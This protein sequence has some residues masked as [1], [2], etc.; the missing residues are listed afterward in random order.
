M[1][2]ESHGTAAPEVSG[3]PERY[4]RPQL[5]VRWTAPL[6]AAEPKDDETVSLRDL[7]ATVVRR[8]WWVIGTASTIL[9]IALIQVFTVRPTY[10]ARAVMQV[11]PP[12]G[13]LVPSELSPDLRLQVRSSEEYVLTQA[14]K[15]R[16]ATLARRVIEKLDLGSNE[17]FR[18]PTSHGALLDAVVAS[19]RAIKAILP[20]PPRPPAG[21]STLVD[22]FL[23]SVE[24]Q[25]LRDTRLIAVTFASPDRQLS[26]DTLNAL[27]DEF[28]EQT[29]EEQYATTTHV[30]G[31]L[32]QQLEELR[33]KVDESEAA[34]NAFAA[35]NDIV[36]LDERQ[37]VTERRLAD[38]TGALTVV[39]DELIGQTARYQAVRGASSESF[40]S[41]LRNP[42]M[43]DVERRL[44]ERRAQLAL[45]LS[46][47]GPDWP[48]VKQVR[49]EIADLEAQSIE[50]RRDALAMARGD[51]EVAYDRTRK[52]EAAIED[53]KQAVD[54][55]NQA[56]IQ[57]NN[58]KREVDTN[59]EIYAGLL[60]RLKEAGVIA[61]LA[62]SNIRAVERASPPREPSAPK[63]VRDLAIATVL[64]LLIGVG[65]AFVVDSLD[66]AV[67]SADEVSRLLGLP[68][69]GE[70]PLVKVEENGNR[71]GRFLSRQPAASGPL[72]LVGGEEHGRAMEAYR[73][74]RT[75]ILLS[76]SERPPQRILVTSALPGDGKT[77]TA[78]N[79]GRALAQTGARTVLIDLDM[80]RMSLGQ[81]F[82]M[83]GEQGLST[84]LAGTSDLASQ[85]RD[86]PY[87][88]LL[89]V[90]AG[91]VAPNPAELIG[92]QRMVLGLQ[93]VQE[94]FN[95]VVVD[96][97]PVLDVTDAIVASTWMDGVVLVVR[98]GATPREAVRKAAHRLNMVGAK[99]LGVVVNAVD[100]SRHGHSYYS[101]YYRYGYGYYPGRR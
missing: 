89:V 39:E 76:S 52:L 97:P 20:G 55:L 40:P 99:I 95:Y 59:Q 36:N 88:K 93:L 63:K 3:L 51:Y 68:V 96:S 38:L 41:T 85:V 42:A 21:D 94:Y 9:L 17:T 87:D 50:Q 31:F 43:D 100:G 58:L 24:A 5:P 12:D 54:R 91:P 72:L 49:G 4:E 47:Y 64:G 69:L 92:S 28:L 81:A 16:T 61:G 98:A 27:L 45:L 86:T 15:L 84:Y 79:L 83:D 101:G 6:P 11:D 33:R 37:T 44:S 26:A 82:G 67:T 18:T 22:R 2:Q 62:P 65:L 66:N 1:P 19:I 7:L 60:Q 29:H 14:Q 10:T 53:Q 25:A 70:V 73:A 32:Q 30:T 90:P 57:Y 71:R 77:T 48:E 13:Q 75:S 80:R 8:R 74:I 34:L 23:G 35:A 46:T 56:S 78:I